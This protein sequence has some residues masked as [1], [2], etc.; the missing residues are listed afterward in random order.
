MR[1]IVD[2]V[3]RVSAL[4]SEINAASREQSAGI[5]Q[6]AAVLTQLD[7]GTQQNAALVEELSA[8]ARSLD[9]QSRGLVAVMSGL[10]D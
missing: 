10:L 7:Q 9:D 5:Q 6:A 1:D 8:N 3:R 2:S 4:I